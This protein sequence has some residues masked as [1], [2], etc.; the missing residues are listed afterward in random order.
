VAREFC[1]QGGNDRIALLRI[2]AGQRQ[3]VDGDVDLS[4]CALSVCFVI[5]A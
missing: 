1:V 3:A 2:E 4:G 5:P